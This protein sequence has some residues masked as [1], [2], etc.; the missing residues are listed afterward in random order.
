MSFYDEIDEYVMR[1][2]NDIALGINETSSYQEQR[3]A[4][5]RDKEKE[6]S[7]W[8]KY[9]YQKTGRT[10]RLILETFI[11]VSK[12]PEY[13]ISFKAATPIN[14]A[15]MKRVFVELNRYLSFPIKTITYDIWKENEIDYVNEQNGYVS[16]NHNQKMIEVYD[17]L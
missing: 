10:S 9:A 14:V 6:T 8:S 5:L 11:L 1:R 3:I 17:H 16:L 2:K 12:F 4:F 13:T 7:D 15:S